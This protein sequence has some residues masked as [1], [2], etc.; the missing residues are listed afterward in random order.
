MQ[1]NTPVLQVDR[2]EKIMQMYGNIL[3]RLCLLMLGN[4]NDAEDVVQETFLKYLRK[5]PD[6]ENEEHEKAWLI[7]VATNHCK[8]MLRFRQRHPIVDLE[9]LEAFVQD[10]SDC[11]ILDVLM[12][13][14]EKFKMVLLLYYVEE[15][16][17]EEI[18]KV[19]GKTKS[20]VKMRLQKGRKLLGEAYRKRKNE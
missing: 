17:I 10:S 3:F 7:T 14:P 4:A 12:T 15:Y 8:D 13:L 1:H 16:S 5:A 2:L 9:E 6:F 20:A 19:I 11:E 18:A